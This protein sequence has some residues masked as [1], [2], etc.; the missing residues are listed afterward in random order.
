MKLQKLSKFTIFILIFGALEFYLIPG[1]QADTLSFTNAGATGAN[2]PT[3]AQIDSA[4][5]SSNLAGTVVINSQGF[6][7]WTVPTSGTYEITVAGASGGSANNST[8]SGG[9]G[10]VITATFNLS[11]GDSL[12]IVVG[13]QGLS[14]SLG[15]GGGGGG[16]YVVASGSTTGL[17]LAAGGG[18]GAGKNGAGNDAST[19]TSAG[20]ATYGS[21]GGT[22]NAA[23]ATNSG[24]STL[25]G[26]SGGGASGRIANDITNKYRAS[27]ISTINTVTNHSFS[28]NG[29]VYLYGIGDNFDGN[30]RVT[31]VPSTKSFSFTNYSTDFPSQAT[32]GSYIYGSNGI[33][34]AGSGGLGGGGGAGYGGVGGKSNNATEAVVARSYLAGSRGGFQSNSSFGSEIN[35]SGGFGGGGTGTSLNGVY[36]GGGGGGYTGGGGGNGSSNNGYGGTGGG[37]GGSYLSGANQ[38][39]SVSNSGMGYVNITTPT[40][41]DTTAPSFTS[42]S[43]FSAAENI[44]ITSAAATIKVSESATV[45]IS[46]GA[47]SALFNI[48]N[49]DSVTAL[50]RFKVSPNFE[51]P[52]DSGGNNVY[53]LVLT[54]TDPSNNS[55]TQTI[56]ITVTDVVDTSSFNSFSVSGTPTFRT[57]VTIT[58][59]VSVAAKVT[60]R[61]K[62]VI[63]AGCKD[64]TASGSGSSFTATCS[65]RPSAR[66]AVTPTANAVPTG[67][68]IS[69]T[70]ATPINVMVGNRSGRR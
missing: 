50:I 52:S 29:Q 60:F 40:I 63:I 58:A 24:Y 65:W 13:Q 56:T 51:S 19:S 59:S 39:T 6:Q 26:G 17:I 1:A 34:G 61:A 18:G 16:T 31:S 32:S 15:A 36:G 45:T 70:T 22:T 53:D 54:A 46:S 28:T 48:S 66:G 37:G 41:P 67:A 64:I 4:Y 3:Q 69:S 42:S 43:S 21:Y 23:G 9:K 25:Y 38:I 47:D 7:T 44:A 62:N 55:G 68:G 57:V 30:F 35:A 27:N 5:V 12:T 10:A 33:A 2:G 8:Y 11:Q 14:S 49:S 20:Q